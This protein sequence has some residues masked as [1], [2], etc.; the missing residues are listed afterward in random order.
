MQKE[1]EQGKIN[2]VLLHMKNHCALQIEDSIAYIEK[3]ICSKRKEF[4][5]HVL[6]DEFSDLSKPYKDIHMSLCKV[7]EMFFNKKNRFDSDTEML[8][9][10]KKALYDPI[11]IRK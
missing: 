4:M 9:D 11:N 1:Q 6:M 3:I 5:E 8:E 2:S 7:F 10:I